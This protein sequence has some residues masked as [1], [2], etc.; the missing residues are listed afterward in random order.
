MRFGIMAMQLEAL[1]PS[2]RPP[3]EI[4]QHIAAFDHIRLIQQIVEQGFDLIEL[5]GDLT[6]FLPQSFSPATVE[7][8][9]GLKE[10]LGLAFTVHLPL[11]SV[12]PSTPL[13][14][15]REGSVHAVTAVIRDTKP[16]APESYVLHATGAL[17]AEFYRMRLPESARAILLQQFQSAARQSLLS[18]LNETG[19]QGRRIS[20]E[21]IEFPFEMTLDLAEELDL[22]ICLDTGHIL[23]GFSGPVGLFEALERSLPRLGEVH[24][25]DAPW[26]GAAKIIG[27]GKDH[28]TL[29]KGD[30]ELGAFLDR[31][32]FANYSGPIIMELMVEQAKASLEMIR[33]VRPEYLSG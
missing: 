22:S 23:A 3:E 29:G 28:Q 19:I 1:I 7:A 15:V 11:W 12:E 24:L 33:S 31:L 13:S 14:P 5:G 32:H 30:L 26:Q 25:H 18:I 8:L 20:I 4:L 6:V 17:A 10:Q 9:A 27:Y 21:T 2:R 16:L